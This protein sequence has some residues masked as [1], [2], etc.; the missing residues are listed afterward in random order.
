MSEQD[1]E[2]IYIGRLVLPTYRCRLRSELFAEMDGQARDI[3]L[4]AFTL[5]LVVL[6][7]LIGLCG[8]LLTLP[9]G[10]LLCR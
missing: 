4:W 10:G 1:T 3:P 6:V 2:P 5:V 9:Y 8:S 7:I